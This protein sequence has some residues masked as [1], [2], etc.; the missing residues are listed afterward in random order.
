MTFSPDLSDPFVATAVELRTIF[1]RDAVARDKAGGRPVEQIRLL[2]ESGLPSAQ[3]PKNYG[4]KGAPW[5][6]VLRV[7][8]EFARTDGSLAHLYGYHHLPLNGVLFRGTDAQKDQLLTR[9]ARENWVWGNSGNA[10]SKTSTARRNG[11]GWILN[12]FRPFSSGSHIADYIQVAW[13]DGQ[14]RL[15]AAIPADREGIVI[16]DDW[17]GV[18]QRQTGSGKVTFK[19]VHI[20]DDELIGSPAV[21]LTPFQ[22]L[23]SLF[24]Q[25]VLL[26]LFVGSA[27][28]A[29][30]EGRDY[31]VS[32]SRPWVYSGYENHTDD[33][34]VQRK[35]GDLYIRTLAAAELADVAARSLD[36]AYGKGE[37]LTLEQRGQTAIDLA[38][39]NV[40][41]GQIGLDA[42]SEVFEVMGARSATKAN[43][44]DRFWRNV[45]THTLHNPAEY[46]KRTIGTWLLTG[47]FPVGGLYR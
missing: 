20:G 2:K 17:D 29:L 18:G 45:R 46:K 26:N 25:A 8:R 36:A 27:Q 19:D 38:T 4:G 32:Q 7:V 39:A 24:Q 10:M 35:Y 28:G 37:A 41:A 12:G 40:Y 23:I 42:S 5:L 47:E 15:A 14:D 11:S 30:S 21:P 44:Y 33:P 13:E 43:G 9:S 6:S 22:T 3:I 34:F 1:D 31:T 16:E